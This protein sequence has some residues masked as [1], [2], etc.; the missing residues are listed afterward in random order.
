MCLKGCRDTWEDHLVKRLEEEV[1]V[2]EV[3]N[4]RRSVGSLV[5]DDNCVEVCRI[6]SNI[7]LSTL[8]IHFLCIG[9]ICALGAQYWVTDPSPPVP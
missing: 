9:C 7:P 3:S 1:G 5:R 2:G 6:I 8:L 4:D